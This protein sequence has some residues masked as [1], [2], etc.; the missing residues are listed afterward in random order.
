[1]NSY[2]KELYQ[3]VAFYYPR[4]RAMLKPSFKKEL[5]KIVNAH[6]PEIIHCVG[7]QLDGF[8]QVYNARKIVG[9]S[10]HILLAVHGSESELIKPSFLRKMFMNYVENK[11]L[12]LCDYY[13]GVSNY[14]LGM[15]ILSKY[16]SKSLGVVY[17]IPQLNSNYAKIKSIVRQEL[18]LG[19]DDIVV[20]STGRITKE[21]GFERLTSVIKSCNRL[22]YLIV[23][24]GDYLMEMKQELSAMAEQVIFTGYVNDVT[25][26]LIASD[27]F[28]LLTKHETLC[29]S[30]LEAG[31]YK[32]PVISC[33]VGG[34]PEIIKDH[35]NGVLVNPNDDNSVVEQLK[36]LATNASMR[37]YYGKK[38]YETVTE[39]FSERKNM[40]K[41]ACIYERVIDEC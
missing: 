10:S 2:L 24:D 8:L 21:K 41:L 35:E 3:F 27:I 18:G 20:V 19:E 30:I 39:N 7:L 26:Y 5:T 29:N 12:K 1:M 13:Y 33:N 14:T 16:T 25:D 17:N 37:E 4:S 32:L 9:N 34:I 38:L 15:K 40:E 6:K 36:L 28:V 11:Q 31:L 23:G 22:K